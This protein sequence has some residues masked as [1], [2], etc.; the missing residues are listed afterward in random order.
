[1]HLGECS[2][3]NNNNQILFYLVLSL[4]VRNNNINGKNLL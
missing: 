4:H 2:I 1:M 3:I